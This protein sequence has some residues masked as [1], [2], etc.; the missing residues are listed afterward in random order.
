[1]GNKGDDYIIG[2][3]YVGE[4][5]YDINSTQTLDGGPGNDYIVGGDYGYD[6]YLI[7]GIGEDKIYT[8]GDYR[9]GVTY[10]WGDLEYD[11]ELTDEDVWGSADYIE[12][13]ATFDDQQTDL[14]V[15]AGDG[16]DTVLTGT[17]GDYHFVHG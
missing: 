13:L 8:N 16:A 4:Y 17:G 7:G 5:G 12:A 3:E 15:W 14:Y 10:I 1:L 2:G 6:Q 9:Y 11:D